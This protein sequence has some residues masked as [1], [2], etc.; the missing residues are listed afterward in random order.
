M[1]GEITINDSGTPLVEGTDVQTAKCISADAS[2]NIIAGTLNLL[3]TGTGGKCIK[4][5]G[6]ISIGDKSSISYQ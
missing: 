4:S 2:I 5:D 6:T 1:A 3:A